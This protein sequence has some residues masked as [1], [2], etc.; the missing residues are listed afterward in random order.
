MKYNTQKPNQKWIK[1]INIKAK[2]IKLLEQNTE[3]PHDI[4][5]GKIF[6]TKTPKTG[7]KATTGKLDY[8]KLKNLSIKGTQS[9]T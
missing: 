2:T 9:T 6:L 8:I 5:R 1:D 4:K 3:N 7:N